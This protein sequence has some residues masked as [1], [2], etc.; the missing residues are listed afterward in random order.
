MP[1]LMAVLLVFAA[2]VAFAGSCIDCHTDESAMKSM[3]KVKSEVSAEGE[4]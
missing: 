3:V 4:G 2:N 1:K